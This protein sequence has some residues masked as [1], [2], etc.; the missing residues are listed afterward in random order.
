MIFFRLLDLNA[1]PPSR[2]KQSTRKPP[3]NGVGHFYMHLITSDEMVL[4]LWWGS[5]KIIL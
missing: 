2:D 3:K 4:Y 5:Y 1:L